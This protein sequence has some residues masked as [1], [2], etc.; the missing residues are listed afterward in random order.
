MGIRD[1]IRNV[2]FVGGGDGALNV[3]SDVARRDLCWREVLV[4]MRE[5][6]RGGGSVSTVR[7]N[8]FSSLKI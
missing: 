1:E 4:S 6:C 7:L 5:I 8:A 3:W 2:V